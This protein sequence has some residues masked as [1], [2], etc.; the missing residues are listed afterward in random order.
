MS[1]YDELLLSSA[2]LQQLN[3]E[4]IAFDAAMKAFQRDNGCIVDGEATRRK[5]TWQKLLGMK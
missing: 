4:K 5:L 1:I 3:A 2:Q